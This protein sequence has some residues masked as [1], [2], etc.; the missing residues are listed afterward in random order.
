M[1][2]CA[3][4]VPARHR[5]R[6][7]AIL[8][9]LLLVGAGFVAAGLLPARL[10]YEK[11]RDAVEC[12]RNALAHKVC[13]R[14]GMLT[15]WTFDN[16]DPR[17]AFFRFTT[18]CP[19]TE[20]AKGRFGRARKFDGDNGSGVLSGFR[21][22]FGRTDFS[23]AIWLD[24][25]AV[26]QNQE[27]FCSTY[28]GT[29]GLRLQEGR[30][31][32][33]WPEKHGVGSISYPYSQFGRFTHIA[34]T[35]DL[36]NGKARLYENGDL[37]VEG[38]V[39]DPQVFVFRTLFGHESPHAS[40]Y[41]LHGLIDDAA[42]WMRAVKPEEIRR[43]A[44]SGASIEKT[45]APRRLRWRLLATTICA[46]ILEAI[47]RLSEVVRIRP[48]ALF[49]AQRHPVATLPTV[50]V[51]IGGGP[52]R[53]LARAH[54]K[55]LSI[56]RRTKSAAQ[57]ADAFVR[58]HGLP[59]F[60]AQTQSCR[61]ALHGSG[62][63]YPQSRRPSYVLEIPSPEG[64][65]PSFW[66]LAAPESCGW[67]YPAIEAMLERNAGRNAPRIE[68]ARLKVNGSDR[69]IYLF[70]DFSHLGL[71]TG[72]GPSPLD[73]QGTIQ[74]FVA[75]E[76]EV[77]ALAPTNVSPTA[78]TLAPGRKA[79]EA[80]IRRIRAMASALCD[81]SRSPLPRRLREQLVGTSARAL[82]ALSFGA[83]PA[84]QLE[85]DAFAMLGGNLSPQRVTEDLPL[86]E[87]AA[88][89]ADGMRLTFRS[90]DPDVIDDNG[91]IT[92]ALRRDDRPRTVRI[93][94]EVV[95]AD[96]GRAKKV[97]RFRVV[98]PDAKVGALFLTMRSLPCKTFNAD[99]ILVAVH[100]DNGDKR[101]FAAFGESGA[102]VA[103]RGNTS[104]LWNKKLLKI[105]TASPHGLFGDSA[106]RSILAVNATTDPSR[107]ANT[108]G[109]RL[110]QEA[111]GT[112]HPYRAIVP[113]EFFAEL[114]VNGHYYGL[115][116]FSE[117]IDADLLGAEN[118]AFFR[119][120]TGS[121]ATRVISQRRPRP[122]LQD[123]G[124]RLAELE[125][126][127]ANPDGKDWPERIRRLFDMDSLIAM[128]FA[129]S[130]LQNF[131]GWPNDFLFQEYLVYDAA[132]GRFFYIPWDFDRSERTY[133][134]YMETNF[135]RN[136]AAH[137]S[138][139]RAER[140]AAWR[141]LRQGPYSDAAMLAVVDG[142]AEKLRGYVERDIEM[143]LSPDAEKFREEDLAFRKANLVGFARR[144]DAIIDA[145]VPV[146]DATPTP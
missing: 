6:H 25:D 90:L 38:P 36:E 42:V 27:I 97:F 123:F 139:F 19:G 107:T 16:P 58:F 11:P 9:V 72:K 50:S 132:R 60:P 81:D 34:A 137:D 88:H 85:I 23:M 86:A 101:L 12:A 68:A 105:K 136:M 24:L 92:A 99:A 28:D 70:S 119:H 66:L 5:A 112:N 93:Q 51:T 115:F 111:V 14:G 114:F 39:R 22:E 33:E 46:D 75:W 110:F 143:W 96:G 40:F 117:R 44:K 15:Y 41:P 37:M 146:R 55:S 98:P 83:A 80:E 108:L 89:L 78:A 1:T 61:F 32:F 67:L 69:G 74:P 145:D 91:R 125:R 79:P 100:E 59:G 128:Q 17:D 135:G 134:G 54:S 118:M 13:E 129:F 144:I 57:P 120:E 18:L 130:A 29:V 73:F 43:L 131:N 63:Y 35:L 56:G 7:S 62:I 121:H 31:T 102:G 26:A 52:E 76:Q 53:R 10:L 106:T 133:M 82:D 109:Y 122:A 84:T 113:S 30:M 87:A 2:T 116:E 65:D 20:L 141:R 8:A 45:F 77:H 64:G 138:S 103:F 124:D 140:A 142:I 48:A 71:S 94:A 126:L 49:A 127:A 3:Q 4:S 104:F 95:D 47:G 21:M